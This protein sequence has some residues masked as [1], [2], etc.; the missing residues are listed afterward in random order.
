MRTTTPAPAASHTISGL[1]PHGE[2][3]SDPR[4]LV[5]TASDAAAARAGGFRVA[6]VLHT[7][8]G[9]WSEQHLAAIAGTLGDVSIPLLDVIDC[10]FDPD[11]QIAALDRLIAER[12]DAIISLPVDNTAVAEAHL[13]VARAGIKLL[14]LD[15]AP[16]GLLPGKDYVSLV[17]ADNFG[18]GRTAA[19]LMAEHLP[20]GA[21]VGV[22]SYDVDFFATN[23][24]EIAF[25]K[26]MTT[27]RPDV[28]LHT[29][30]FGAPHLAGETARSFLEEHSAL[31]GLFV[32][33]DEPAVPVLEQLEELGA[34]MAV[35][36]VDLG[37]KVAPRLADGTILKG[38]AAQ[39][40]F[41]QGVAMAQVTIL[42]L[43]G[44]QTPAWIA[45]PGIPITPAGILGGYQS[46]W[47]AP[48]PREIME[49][50]E[51]RASGS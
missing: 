3:A 1:G 35:T 6:V 41:S 33:W 50:R 34:R 18:L 45:L 23:Q 19:E 48:A 11:R 29:A 47:R 37:E 13:R 15:N 51:S 14:L 42:S 44:R 36:T 4:R 2:R 8:S 26:W 25:T 32:V 28:T 16:T 27:Q 5:I 31:D 21:S 20:Q 38:V 10:E 49:M 9:N 46:V 30:G 39:N 22:L 43:L 17:S 40:P 7:L 24:R 12:P